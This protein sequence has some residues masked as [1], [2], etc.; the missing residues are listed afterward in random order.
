VRSTI[1]FLIGAGLSLA[2]LRPPPASG[3]ARPSGEPSSIRRITLGEGLRLLDGANPEILLTRR[4]LAAAEARTAAAGA[5]SNPGFSA[6]HEQLGGD[7][8]YAET[9]LA[10]AQSLEIGGQRGL[11]VGAARAAADAAAARVDAERLRVGFELH[12]AYARAAQA[13]EDLG[14]LV[15]TAEEFRRVEQSGAIRFA[16]GDISHFD[17]SRL[18][19]ERARYEML[20]ADAELR[21]LEAG[22]ELAML[23]A[24]DSIGDGLLFLPAERL[25]EMTR[26][27]VELTLPAGLATRRWRPRARL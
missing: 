11:R 17:R 15:A 21:V 8:E 14:V 2:A 16:E 7:T 22:R 10:L 13:E 6:L 23:V 26:P 24:P 1:A 12:R 25:G 5:R 4:A 18:R 20:M 3:Q 19:I 27:A 9:V